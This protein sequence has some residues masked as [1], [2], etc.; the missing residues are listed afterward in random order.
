MKVS[1][2]NSFFFK[3]IIEGKHLS[4]MVAGEALLRPLLWFFVILLLLNYL[5]N[6]YE[7]HTEGGNMAYLFA[8]NK[9]KNIIRECSNDKNTLF[10]FLLET[11]CIIS[12]LS[13]NF[14]IKHIIDQKIIL[15]AIE[16]YIGQG[17]AFFRAE[18]LIR[19]KKFLVYTTITSLDIRV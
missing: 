12:E 17:V 14:A 1:N 13:W 4:L 2:W 6:D 8:I 3:Q 19:C 16:T 7:S 5:T 18:Y 15:N 10:T 11:I 9:F